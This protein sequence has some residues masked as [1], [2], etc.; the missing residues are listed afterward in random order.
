MTEKEI[1][2][3]LKPL[4]FCLYRNGDTGG[5]EVGIA[6][7]GYFAST[8]FIEKPDDAFLREVSGEKFG[9][10]DVKGNKWCDSKYRFTRPEPSMIVDALESNPLFKELCIERG[11]LEVVEFTGDENNY[12]ADAEVNGFKIRT[13]YTPDELAQLN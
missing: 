8:K 6:L 1:T 3:V 2:R 12:Q 13:T 7:G 9:W 4:S 11:I 5:Y 10:M